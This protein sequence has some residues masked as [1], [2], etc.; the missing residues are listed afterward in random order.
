M[1]GFVPHQPNRAYAEYRD[2]R[3]VPVFTP[4]SPFDHIHHG[5]HR[6]IVLHAWASV[7]DHG[8]A[9]DDVSL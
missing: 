6:N 8:P 1:L 5:I 4:D 7:K 9:I 3:C 2:D